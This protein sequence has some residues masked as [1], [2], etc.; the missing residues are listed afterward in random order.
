MRAHALVDTGA[1][2]AFVVRTDAHHPRARRFVKQWLAR[3]GSFVLSD[4]VFAETMT[5]LKA[6]TDGS[7]AVRVGREL[8][9]NSA[10]TWVALGAEGEAEA[11]NVFQRYEDKDWSFTDCALL[12]LARRLG[13]NAVFSFDHH[14]AQMPDLVRLPG[15]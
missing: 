8:R 11:W 14:L 9:S 6:R 13:I 12:V 5:L 7:I 1:I 15:R 10:Y 2:Y 3:A 4:V